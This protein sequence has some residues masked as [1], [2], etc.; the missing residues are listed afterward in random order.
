MSYRIL[1]VEDNEDTREM[2]RTLLAHHGYDVLDAGSGE[3]MLANI[4]AL[5][6]D[7]VILDIKLPG[8]DG[9]DTLKQLRER[10]NTTPVFLF[11]D[12]Y[13]LFQDHVQACG[14]DGFFPKSKGPYEL[15]SAIAEKLPPVQSV[16]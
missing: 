7:L 10:G 14:A 13:D 5:K 8:I 4:D 15:V 2:V 11:S 16:A 9:C 1:V 3:E 12:F 6:P